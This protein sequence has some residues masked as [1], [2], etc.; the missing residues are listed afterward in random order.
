MQGGGVA[1]YAPAREGWVTVDGQSYY[2]ENG[3]PVTG[4]RDIQDNPYDSSNTYYF[5]SKGVMVNGWQT[6]D[7][8]LYYFSPALA[9]GV[10]F[11]LPVSG[12]D[13]SEWADYIFD[14]TGSPLPIDQGWVQTKSGLKYYYES[15]GK[16]A[17]GWKTI[18]GKEYYFRES[19]DDDFSDPKPVASMA[20]GYMRVP[21]YSGGFLFADDGVWVS[22]P[23]W[24]KLDNGLTYY[25]EANGKVAEGLKQIGGSFYR[26]ADEQ[27]WLACDGTQSSSATRCK[28]GQLLVGWYRQDDEFYYSNA[29][30]V[31]QVGLQVI[32]GKT[33]YLADSFD[34]IAGYGD[35]SYG[36][37]R[38]GWQTIA[39]KKYYFGNPGE[40]YMFTGMQSLGNPN[41]LGGKS[42]YLFGDDGVLYDTPGWLQMSNGDWYYVNSDSTLATG[43]KDIGGESYYFGENGVMRTGFYWANGQQYWSDP[44]GVWHETAW[45]Q[46][47]NGWWFDFGNGTYAQNSWQ[48]I[49]DEWYHF[50]SNGYMQVG[51]LYLGGTWYYLAGSGAMQV[52]WL[53][54]G[55]A[56][57]YLNGGGDMHT[58]WKSLGG[59][60]YFLNG[61]GVMQTG[62]LH[63][64]GAWYYLNGGGDM[65][66]GWRKVGGVWYFL[67]SSGDMATGWK[68]IGNAWYYLNGGGDMAENRWIGNYW[69][70][71]DGAMATSAWVDGGKYYVGSDG[72]YDPQARRQ[73]AAA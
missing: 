8:A 73:E 11:S 55:G 72:V 19:A 31:V 23:G 30:G 4:W 61:S 38:C 34:A 22:Q 66:T 9:R 35:R 13:G 48:P 70:G 62:W 28:E 51:W 43:W 44:N 1:T 3:K 20:T 67:N 46:D 50:D 10:R 52:G 17:R 29:Q 45:R 21:G 18:D 40:G 37:R 68:K 54:N 42:L 71:A 47:S 53:H 15:K 26:F 64:G 16:L 63:N 60:W 39:G 33:Y 41:V 58:G 36:L 14:A 56:W 25:I 5:D 12:G 6:I 69:V 65:A 32:D 2:Y 49:G 7:G 27:Y 57:Y 59:T 24:V